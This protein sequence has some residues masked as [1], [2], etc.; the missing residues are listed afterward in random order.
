MRSLPDSLIVRERDP[1]NAETRLGILASG[2]TPAHDFY[3]RSHLPLPSP[4]TASWRLVVEGVVEKRLV[5]S[6]DE[7]RRLPIRTVTM[8][9]ECA[10]N[11]R[12]SLL[13]K[14]EGVP[15]AY[16]AAGTAEFTGVPLPRLL[17]R[18]RVGAA[19]VEILFAGEDRGEVEPG[20]EAAF[21]R[22]LPMEA[23]Q[24]EDVLVAWAMNG[25]ALAPDHGFPLR[26]VV[27]GWYGMASVKWLTRISASRTPFAG[28]YQMQRYVYTGEPGL[29]DGT[30]VT[31]TRVRSLI[32]S[33]ADGAT[34]DGST[35][36]ITGTAWSGEGP[37]RRVEVSTDGGEAW[38]EA[39]LQ[40]TAHAYA[41]T[42]WRL[43]WSPQSPGPH[44][45][46]ARA[47][48]GSGKTQP[49]EPV[50]NVY[51]YGNNAVQR[52]QVAVVDRPTG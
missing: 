47:T 29:A 38:T 39:H 19:A 48:D 18:A 20:K 23:A 24:N 10:G 26:L 3:I 33:P 36:E 37:V 6:L 16:G 14:V 27:P 15:W 11:G 44:T 31:K 4:A 40:P 8:T 41:A 51:G 7:L 12:A 30:P 9:M 28:Y 5:L 46:V 43:A 32:T 42:T 35:V 50:W 49:L 45:L 17:E 25:E 22:S 1:L 21:E 52:V 2:I 13:R 34:L